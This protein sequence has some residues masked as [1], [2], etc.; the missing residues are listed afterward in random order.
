MGVKGN[1]AKLQDPEYRQRAIDNIVKKVGEET[2]K[3][4][5]VTAEKHF[6]NS[7]GGL[8][9]SWYYRSY[10]AVGGDKIS[11]YFYSRKKY[12][13]YL[14]KGTAPHRMDYLLTGGDRSKG[15]FTRTIPQR[16]IKLIPLRLPDGSLIFRYV[17]WKS[18][19][20]GHWFNKGIKAMHF[21][22]EGIKLYKATR[23]NADVKAA[24]HEV[25]D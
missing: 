21:I 25:I 24:I 14:D 1:V 19:L 3:V 8:L 6:R 16:Y 2:V 12:A 18:I 9:K 13:K 5:A 15:R 4:I 10:T 20:E 17:S 11:L 22:S 23:Y 7:K